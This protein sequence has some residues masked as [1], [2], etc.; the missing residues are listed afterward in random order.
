MNEIKM[1]GPERAAILVAYNAFTNTVPDDE[2]SEQRGFI[3]GWLA[4]RYWQ[5]AQREA[6]EAEL[7]R[8]VMK[9]A[10]DSHLL[11]CPHTPGC[12][13]FSQ[14]DSRSGG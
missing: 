1:D 14:C 5:Q 13:T 3:A 10:R 6:V 4:A 9:P 8:R 12:L 2:T 7:T 11:D